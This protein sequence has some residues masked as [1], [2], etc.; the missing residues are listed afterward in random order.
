MCIYIAPAQ[1]QLLKKLKDKVNKTVDKATGTDSPKT[2]TEK[3]E[4]AAQP[5]YIDETENRE[6]PIFVDAAPANGKMVLK[7]KKD[8][9]F[10]GGYIAVTGQPK[11]GDTTANVLDFINA[12]VGSLYN[13]GEISNNAFY[14]DGQRIL[15]DP[16]II[17]LRPQFISY[18]VNTTPF[19]TSTKDTSSGAGFDPMGAMALMQANGN[20]PMTDADIEA[21]K[22]KAIPTI[23]PPTFSFNYNG[24]AYRPF[25]GI[26]EQMLVLQSMT[27]GKPTSKFYGFGTEWIAGDGGSL[28]ISALVQT[29]K[30]VLRIE[31]SL[32]GSLALSYPT[33]YM[34][35][36]SGGKV[37]TFSNG[38]TV[39]VLKV[40]GI[41]KNM[42]DA[43]PVTDKYFSETYGTDSGHVVCI[44]SQMGKR[45]PVGAV[46]DYK[47]VLTYPVEMEKKNLL[48]ASNP[49]KSV[50]YKIHTLYYPDGS[51]ET[52]DNVGDAQLV[53]FNGKEYIVWFEMKK[54][55]DGH[56]IYVCQK[57][58]K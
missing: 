1:A 55:T 40:P 35:F 27:D 15:N 3:K 41:K 9:L 12:R 37:N 20:K 52:I 31:D 14:F 34:A 44:V 28:K 54:G 47:T 39:Q 48:I 5:E 30:T 10:W 2:E 13:A 33:G 18:G 38:K 29:E 53:S 58:L 17:P 23:I 51:K 43:T 19:F 46:I 4:D 24:K 21:F 45:E 11:K 6:R 57:Q 26:G 8:D 7:L 22:K 36:C 50:M 16:C 42:G 25:T 56:E 49:A 32:L